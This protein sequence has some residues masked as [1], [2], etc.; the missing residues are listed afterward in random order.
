M[1]DRLREREQDMYTRKPSVVILNSLFHTRDE[2]FLRRIVMN[3]F[4]EFFKNESMDIEELKAFYFV[5]TREPHLY[6]LMSTVIK[7]SYTSTTK[8]LCTLEGKNCK[9]KKLFELTLFVYQ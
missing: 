3:I 6:K 2:K 4:A 1:N 7:K 9:F 5:T 8:V